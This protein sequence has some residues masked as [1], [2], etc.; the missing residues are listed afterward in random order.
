MRNRRTVEITELFN[1]RRYPYFLEIIEVTFK[2]DEIY[3]AIMAKTWVV[4]PKPHGY[5]RL[6]DFERSC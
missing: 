2:E 4:S 1:A 6:E 3:L 5:N